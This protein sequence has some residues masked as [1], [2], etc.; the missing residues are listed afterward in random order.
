MDYYQIKDEIAR[1]ECVEYNTTIGRNI[2]NE[3]D[4]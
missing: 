3:D 1:M 2:I 4:I